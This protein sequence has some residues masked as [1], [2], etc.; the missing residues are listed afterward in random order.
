MRITCIECGKECR[1]DDPLWLYQQ[2][3]RSRPIHL[4][5]NLKAHRRDH[6][7]YT[8]SRKAR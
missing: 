2:G 1:A 7:G 5:C 4:D 6:P 8:S 3:M